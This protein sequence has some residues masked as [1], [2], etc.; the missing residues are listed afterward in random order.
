M[1]SGGC[2]KGQVSE[3]MGTTL[4]AAAFG[5]RGLLPGVPGLV[6]GPRQ[7]G[8]HLGVNERCLGVGSCPDE[9]GE[10]AAR[11]T[12]GAVLPRAAGSV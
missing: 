10:Q 12:R 5:F 6:P 2:R 9:R 4:L 7:V 3:R 8:P 1:S 11:P